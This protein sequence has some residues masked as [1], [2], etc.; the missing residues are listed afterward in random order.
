L[1]FIEFAL[2]SIGCL[3]LPLVIFWGVVGDEFR[4]GKRSI[5]VALTMKILLIAWLV[6]APVVGGSLI[7]IGGLG[8]K[9]FLIFAAVV[10]GLLGLPMLL[11]PGG[12]DPHRN[13]YNSGPDHYCKGPYCWDCWRRYHQ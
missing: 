13:E 12:K 5:N 7:L 8:V 1:G 9:G 10:V 3:A 11:P 4:V 6:G 2:S